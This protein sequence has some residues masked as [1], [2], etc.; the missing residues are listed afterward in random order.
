MAG[1]QPLRASDIKL[2][3]RQ[4]NA[5]SVLDEALWLSSTTSATSVPSTV[6]A[7]STIT[8]TSTA[9]GAGVTVVSDCAHF[10]DP[11][12]NVAE[13]C[14]CSGYPDTLPLLPGPD[15]C[16]YST[17]LGSV[18]L[19]TTST[20]TPTSGVINYPFTSTAPNGAVVAY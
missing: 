7:A 17:I 8:T 1:L 14:Q 12:D 3:G 4:W 6:S 16:A 10:A 9:L 11:D 20:S 5:L 2:Y 13:G 15:P 19:P 18:P